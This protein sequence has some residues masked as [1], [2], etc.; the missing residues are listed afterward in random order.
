MELFRREGQS[1]GVQE[2]VMK[3]GK[4]GAAPQRGRG[5]GA[6]RTGSQR[7]LGHRSWHIQPATW[8]AA[9]EYPA[10]DLTFGMQ[11]MPSLD[12]YMLEE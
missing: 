1:I 11:H 6:Q 10:L 8:G 4:D 7:I 3:G 9:H 5:L 12:P 2:S